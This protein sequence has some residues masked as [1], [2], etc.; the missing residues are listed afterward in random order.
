MGIRMMSLFDKPSSRRRRMVVVD[1]SID[2]YAGWADD[3]RD[4]SLRITLATSGA[5]ALALLPSHCDVDWIVSS[6]LPDMTG[7][8]LL[9]M[10]HAIEPDLPVQLVTNQ[11]DMDQELEAYRLGAKVCRVKRNEPPSKEEL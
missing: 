8:E 10:L 6:D 7:L 9:H 2:D 5:D 3:T 11:Y 4:G 1:P